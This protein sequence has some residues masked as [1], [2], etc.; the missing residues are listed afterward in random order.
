M[1]LDVPD[2]ALAIGR[3]RQETKP[4]YAAALKE[5]LAEAAREAKAK[6]TEG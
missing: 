6:K 4:G 2:D 1:T 5:R 3:V